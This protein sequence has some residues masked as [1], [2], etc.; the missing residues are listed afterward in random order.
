MNRIGFP[1]SIRG[2][3]LKFDKKISFRKRKYKP[4]FIV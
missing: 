4:K 3:P 1:N 2:T